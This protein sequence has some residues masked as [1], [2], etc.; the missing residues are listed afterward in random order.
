MKIVVLMSVLFL[1]IAILVVLYCCVCVGKQAEKRM[2]DIRRI[3][4]SDD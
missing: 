2:E 1:I 4:G 3:N